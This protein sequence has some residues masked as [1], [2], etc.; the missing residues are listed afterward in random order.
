M[1]NTLFDDMFLFSEFFK[2]CFHDRNLTILQ[3]LLNLPLFKFKNRNIIKYYSFI[4]FKW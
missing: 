3:N 4:Q 2:V 1:T